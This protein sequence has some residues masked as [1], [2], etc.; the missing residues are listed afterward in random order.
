MSAVAYAIH[1]YSDSALDIDIVAYFLDDHIIKLSPK[2][3][4]I[5]VTDFLSL[6]S[7]AKSESQ[8]PII[9]TTSI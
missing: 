8:Y 6:G 3:T 9:L 7:A 1:L 2:K 4:H 5:P